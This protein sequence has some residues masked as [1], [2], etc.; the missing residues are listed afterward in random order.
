MMRLNL[1]PACEWGFR[2]H[3]GGARLF[4]VSRDGVLRERRALCR[5]HA[6]AARSTYGPEYKITE[7]KS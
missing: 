1:L 4:D 3:E 2:C 7:T 5:Y 6:R